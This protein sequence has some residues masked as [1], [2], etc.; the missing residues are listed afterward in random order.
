MNSFVTHSSDFVQ[1]ALRGDL[2]ATIMLPERPD[3][4]CLVHIYR[5][6]DCD[7]SGVTRA[8]VSVSSAGEMVCR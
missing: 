4:A 2:L 5:W 7:S 6:K 3:L 8:T 1:F